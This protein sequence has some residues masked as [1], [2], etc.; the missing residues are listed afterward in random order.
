MIHNIDEQFDI[1]I[2]IIVMGIEMKLHMVNVIN[3]T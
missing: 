3:T 2:I 1:I